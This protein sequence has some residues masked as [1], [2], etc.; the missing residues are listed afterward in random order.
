V[1]F[2]EGKSAVVRFY[3]ACTSAVLI[4]TLETIGRVLSPAQQEY[5]RP[6]PLGHFK[7][8]VMLDILGKA[9]RVW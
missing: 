3:G 5:F 8:D 7:Y 2:I 4:K 6:I 9:D 1:N